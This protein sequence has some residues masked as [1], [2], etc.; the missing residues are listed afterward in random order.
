[1][2]KEVVIYLLLMVFCFAAGF[3][4]SRQSSKSIIKDSTAEI[5]VE[6]TS[7][8]VDTVREILPKPTDEK[9]VRKETVILAVAEKAK[10]RKFADVECKEETDEIVNESEEDQTPGDST[11]VE[12]PVTQKYYKG[13]GYEI[14][15]SGYA[16]QLDSAKIYNRTETIVARKEK[17]P[18]RW[19]LGISVGYGMTPDG[20]QPF[21]GITLTYSLISF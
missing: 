12:L 4:M 13:E 7:V 6:E 21:A 8:S 18:N 15:V 11:A 5:T 17:P 2:K 10:N 16:Q 1:M 20:M 3:F 14:W 9:P 19:H